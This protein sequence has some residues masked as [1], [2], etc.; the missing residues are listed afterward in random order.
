MRVLHL[1]E[2]SYV[3]HQL[4]L[5]LLTMSVLRWLIL[6]KMIGRN[7]FF[8]KKQSMFLDMFISHFISAS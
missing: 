4:F 7:T 2:Y 8:E 3:T 5:L 1:D 6:S